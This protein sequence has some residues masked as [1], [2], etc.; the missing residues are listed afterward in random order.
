M[1]NVCWLVFAA[2]E[3]ESSGQVN[4]LVAMTTSPTSD[5]S[6]FSQCKLELSQSQLLRARLAVRI[7]IRRFANTYSPISK[8]I[9][10]S[11]VIECSAVKRASIIPDRD[12]ILISPL[13][14][15]SQIVIV[16]NDSLELGKKF[17]TFFSIE[18]VDELRKRT[19]GVKTLPT[20]YWI[21]SY[22]DLG[23]HCLRLNFD[24]KILHSPTGCTA[25]K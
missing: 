11:L 5:Q 22:C 19:N 21:G 1:K 16:Q 12:I 10:K 20:C 24:V 25:L 9:T 8:T 13:E 7:Q 6:R 17:R 15:Y 18:F 23:Q 4:V 2:K 3:T 14:S